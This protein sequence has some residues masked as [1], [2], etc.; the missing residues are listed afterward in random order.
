MTLP[1]TTDRH[2][3]RRQDMQVI[4]K[5]AAALMSLALL[6]A[7]SGGA[8]SNP[9]S[10]SG[11]AS[12]SLPALVANPP[13][14]QPAPPRPELPHLTG[15]LFW[16]N[17]TSYETGDGRLW[18]MDLATGRMAAIGSGW[19]VANAINP[20]VSPDGKHLVFMG[21][22]STDSDL[23]W[24]VFLSTWDDS[25][26]GTPVNLTGP[27]GKSDEDPKFSPD[28]KHIVFKINGAVTEMTLDGKIT[29]H[30]AGK[31]PDTGQPYYLPNGTDVMYS[32][33]TDPNAAIIE[34]TAAGKRRVLADLPDTTDYYP[35]GADST[36]FFFTNVQAETKYD[37]IMRGFYDGS[38]PQSLFFNSNKADSSDA[39]P[40]ADGSRYLFYVSDDS[41]LSG[42]GYDIMVADLAAEKVY[43]LSRWNKLANT[44]IEEVG[45]A[46]SGKAQFPSADPVLAPNMSAP[47]GTL[48]S[49]GKPASASSSYD[50][51]PPSKAVDGILTGKN[52]WC[53][54]DQNVLPSPYWQVDLGAAHDVSG[55]L[56]HF[57]PAAADIWYY[58]IQTSPDSK[59]WT[60]VIDARDNGTLS[61]EAR[62]QFA[63]PVNTRYVRVLF[64]A[65]SAG[66]NWPA[67]IEAQV[68][69][70]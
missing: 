16:H 21:D 49:Q 56:L 50:G 32:E 5:V 37:R 18:Q 24:D 69:G 14:E 66:R 44:A 33:G 65:L 42:G 43:S 62:Y 55:M 57:Y 30:I 40:Y 1:L 61:S 29:R 53:V 27:N 45:L 68:Y 54:A 41:A 67:L 35:I 23:D 63:A 17:Y 51:Y 12:N 48:L 47:P 38:T 20:H 8:P 59:T 4:T 9:A 28:G 19:D 22:V 58:S 34:R 31:T 11:S 36:S 3:P 39:Y 25:N 7:C 15:Q 13:G 70:T 52:C 2:H 64:N 6:P 26:W 46:W 10:P 60:T